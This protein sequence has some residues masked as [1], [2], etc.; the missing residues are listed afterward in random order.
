ML[1]LFRDAANVF[2]KLTFHYNRKQQVSVCQ[3]IVKF[4][5]AIKLTGR[6]PLL[7]YINSC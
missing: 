4:N 3:E 5:Y 2:K 7:E 6:Y 1:E